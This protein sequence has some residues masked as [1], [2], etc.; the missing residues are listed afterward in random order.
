M[1]TRGHQSYLEV[2]LGSLRHSNRGDS[3]LATRLAW[4]SGRC[5]FREICRGAYAVS[6]IPYSSRDLVKSKNTIQDRRCCEVGAAVR[7]ERER[8]AC[9]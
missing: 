7:T 1:T 9:M 8:E 3:P 5:S 6:A 4:Y 2:Q